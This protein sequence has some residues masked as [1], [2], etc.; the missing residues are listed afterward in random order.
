MNRTEDI[1]KPMDEDIQNSPLEL[2]IEETHEEEPYETQDAGE[3]DA[4]SDEEDL[5][6]PDETSVVDENEDENED[7]DEDEGE[8][9]NEDENEDEDEET[10]EEE[11]EEEEEEEETEQVSAKEKEKQS[12]S[13]SGKDEEQNFKMRRLLRNM[14][15]DDDSEGGSLKDMFNDI[16]IS[17]EWV[18]RHWSFLLIVFICMLL[19]VTN[20]YQA[21][22]EIIEEARLKQELNDWKYVWLTQFSELTRSSRQSHIEESLK[23]RGDSTL[24]LSKD[25]PFIIKVK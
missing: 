23:H 14:L 15:R 24:K 25:A 3:E 10:E 1:N 21:Q 17:G 22:Q 16:Q 9:G 7:E 8:E 11:T 5:T 19:F 6:G 2:I 12:P 13:S 18:K 4:L 20:R